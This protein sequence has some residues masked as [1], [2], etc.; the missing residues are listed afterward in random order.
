MPSS[1]TLPQMPICSLAARNVS[2]SAAFL[3]ISQPMRI[4]GMPKAFD[5]DETLIAFSLS[6]AADGRRLP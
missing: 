3:V 6:E 4:P 5:S 2:C 1:M